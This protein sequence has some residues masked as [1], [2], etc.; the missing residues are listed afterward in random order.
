MQTETSETAVSEALTVV[1]QYLCDIIPPLLA[2]DGISLLIEQPPALIASEIKTWV[3]EQFR[4]PGERA[5][6]ADYIF[7]AMKK[8]EEMARL[9]LVA[10]SSLTD[11]LKKLESIVM[12]FCPDEERE[13]LYRDLQALG[14]QQTNSSSPVTLI[15]RPAAESVTSASGGNGKRLT[16]EGGGRSRRFSLLLDRLLRESF[17]PSDDSEGERD[18]ELSHILSAAAADAK[19]SSE[20]QELRRS[21]ASIGLDPGTEDLFRRLGRSLPGWVVPVHFNSGN[22]APDLPR[23][24][25]VEAMSQFLRLAESRRECEK[26]LQELVEAAI[27]QFNAGSLG[28]SVTML[29]LADRMIVECRINTDTESHIRTNCHT[30]LDLNR[31]RSC[32]DSPESHYLLRKILSFFHPYRPSNLLDSL[33]IEGKRERRRLLLGLVKVY[34][35]EARALALQRLEELAE[36]GDISADWYF[37][38]NLLYVLSQIPRSGD[39]S[40]AG[41]IKLVSRFLKT[42]HPTP[43]IREALTVLGQTEN[44]S[45]EELLIV[46]LKEVEASLLETGNQTVDPAKLKLLLD[47]TIILLSHYGTPRAYGAVVNHGLKRREEF[48]DTLARLSHLSNQDL[49][50]DPGSVAKLLSAIRAEIP[51]K[52]LGVVVQKNS[53]RLTQLLSAISS[54]RLPEVRDLLETIVHSFPAR[55]FG[56]AA[57]AALQRL[58]SVG[59]NVDPPAERLLGD[60]DLVSIPDLLQQIA[61]SQLTGTLTI[62]NREG[63]VVGTVS[64]RAG[65]MTECFCGMLENEVALYQ[66]IE[67]PVPGTFAYIGHRDE[68]SQEPTEA[69]AGAEMLPAIA[70]G[71]RR[72]DEFQRARALVPDSCVFSPSQS[73]P[74]PGFENSS[75]LTDQLWMRIV[76]GA[77]PDECE[78]GLNV[79]SYTI[80]SALARWVEE[81]ALT[82]V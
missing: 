11:Y 76:A 69:R 24:S 64:T 49:S 32:A 44:E 8:L 59:R 18:E 62:R 22:E 79:D 36:D 34:A 9:Q 23:N 72:H 50:A 65:R 1:Q 81:S 16:S 77:T 12:E 4:G 52:L 60:L 53:Q 38:R 51:S 78:A 5:S 33:A 13:S 42:T 2:A 54:T 6:T 28:R 68:A 61:R 30:M 10:R 74:A 26:R 46:F 21:L 3:H 47:R 67:K 20:M 15:H 55:D 48:G 17:R 29:E 43:V 56:K 45:A 27:E 63:D 40:P 19:T 73:Q 66:M 35:G 80:R 82:I 41:E 37:P 25:V 58:R 70:E 75:N 71:L 7:H 14:R 39:A 57:L 31:L